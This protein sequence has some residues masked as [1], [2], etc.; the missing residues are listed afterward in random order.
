[1]SYRFSRQATLALYSSYRLLYGRERVLLSH[2]IERLNHVV[3][4][5][6]LKIW[7][8]VLQDRAEYFQRAMAI[9]N[10]AIAQHKERLRY[11]RIRSGA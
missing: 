5:D 7:V 3:D 6:D 11:A 8:Q 9:K 4:L 1:M 2:V 10:L